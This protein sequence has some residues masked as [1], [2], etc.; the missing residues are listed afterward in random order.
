[1]ASLQT[2]VQS[3]MSENLFLFTACEQGDLTT[4]ENYLDSVSS[5]D[6]CSICDENRA[7]LAHYASRFGHLNI[8]KYFLEV[9]RIDIS[10]LRTDHG[11]TCVHDAAVCNQLHI[12]QYVFNYYKTN[13]S[14]TLRWNIRDKEGN[15]TL[16][17]GKIK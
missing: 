17:L 6:I 7:T 10:Q 13:L 11:A 14:N 2:R 15:T 16:H 4:I 3:S 8:L 5:S 12:L 1:M 9:K